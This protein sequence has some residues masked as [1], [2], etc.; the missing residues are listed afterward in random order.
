MMLGTPCGLYYPE[1]CASALPD[2]LYLG[3][4]GFFVSHNLLPKSYVIIVIV[5]VHLVQI[6]RCGCGAND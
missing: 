1:A 5:F 6:L 4:I 3:N 2:N